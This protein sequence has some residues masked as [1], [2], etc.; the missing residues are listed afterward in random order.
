MSLCKLSSSKLLPE[1]ED[2]SIQAQK[3][4]SLSNESFICTI[5]S[6]LLYSIESKI[7]SDDSN[8]PNTKKNIQMAKS[9]QRVISTH[10][11]EHASPIQSLSR[12]KIQNF[13]SIF[14]ID[15]TGC[16]SCNKFE[17]DSFT[18]KDSYIVSNP[19]FYFNSGWTGLSTKSFSFRL[20]ACCYLSKQIITCDINTGMI[21][22]TKNTYKPP[23]A[24]KCID[25]N[26]TAVAET[27]IISIWDDRSR[28]NDGCCYREPIVNGKEPIWTICASIDYDVLVAGAD[29]N[30]YVYDQRN[31]KTKVKCCTPC[32]FDVVKLIPS[33]VKKDN[34][35]V[36]GNDNEIFLYD[37]SLDKFNARPPHEK[38]ESKVPLKINEEVPE[39]VYIPLKELPDNSLS[40]GK[41]KISHARG[42]KGESK[43]MGIDVYK[44]EINSSE[45]LHSIC[46][47]GNVYVLKDSNKMAP[48]TK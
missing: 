47:V 36:A 11:T 18:I 16:I 24:I 43:W 35:Y 12:V 22:N 42:F 48:I 46:D 33:F 8:L 31:W 38:L 3:L 44:D 1:A 17:N 34:Y 2:L 19:K 27:G 40:T 45:V 7:L 25:E 23:T 14:A 20:D 4:C 5:G 26:V 41:L 10:L 28:E 39:K 21:I 30:I 13:D 37:I 9:S 15:S 32:K 29:R 6:N